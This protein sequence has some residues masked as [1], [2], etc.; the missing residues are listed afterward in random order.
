[1]VRVTPAGYMTCDAAINAVGRERY[2]DEWNGKERSARAGL[3]SIEQWEHERVTLGRAI[4]GSGSGA[5][6]APG[7]TPSDN[8]GT[9]EYQAERMARERLEATVLTLLQWLE[10]A[11]ING[12]ALDPWSGKI[13]V[14]PRS[15]WRRNN[16]AKF[17]DKETA[18]YPGV[19]S[20]QMGTLYISNFE[21][22]KTKPASRQLTAAQR[23]R[24]VEILRDTPDLSRREQRLMVMREF[25]H[26]TD[27][28]WRDVCIAAGKRG[29]GRRT[30]KAAV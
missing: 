3:I 12:A 2:G 16:A 22:Q 24:A 23:K 14:L 7:V 9:R 28:A 27:D 1:M 10:A 15:T 13:H 26:M 4:S 5:W 18:P 19:H 20:E 11:T 8:P 17:I 21:V 6:S 29:S 25:K 30:K